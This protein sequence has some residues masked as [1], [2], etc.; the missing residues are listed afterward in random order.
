MIPPLLDLYR[1]AAL[2]R[3][4][5]FAFLLAFHAHAHAVDDDID[6]PGRHRVNEVDRCME[7]VVLAN[8][9]F[10]RAHHEAL[11]VVNA[12]I[13][14]TYSTSVTTPGPLTDAL[15]LSGNLMVLAVAFL[16]GGWVHMQAIAA[17]L[18]PIVSQDQLP[19]QPA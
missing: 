15:R 4:D 5:A 11:I 6:E 12:L 8:C 19:T 2:N 7:A 14:S 9:D 1:R 3:D 16:C 13:A 18:W 10:W 17:E